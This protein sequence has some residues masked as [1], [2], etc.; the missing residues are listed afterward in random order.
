MVYLIKW[1]IS[2]ITPSSRKEGYSKD[3]DW[4]A[5][6]SSR[7]SRAASSNSG[8]SLLLVVMTMSVIIVISSSFMLLSFNTGLSS[9]F[10]SAQHKAQLSC[11]SVAEG[12]KDGNTFGSIVNQ[13][14][15][16]LSG[17]QTVVFDVNDSTLDGKT[18]VKLEPTTSGGSVKSVKVTVTT[19]VG[20]SKYE[21][22]FTH[23]MKTDSVRDVINQVTN[24]MS[25]S[26]GGSFSMQTGKVEG[27]LSLDGDYLLALN[28]WKEINDKTDG[29]TGW[30]IY[31]GT[32]DGNVYVNGSLVLGYKGAS[33]QIWKEECIGTSATRHTT[34]IP[35]II[36]ENLYVNGDLIINACEIEG[37]VYVSGNVLVNG[38]TDTM[39]GTETDQGSG[40]YYKDANNAVIKGNL[41]VGGSLYVTTGSFSRYFPDKEQVVGD[42]GST[43][44]T[45]GYRFNGGFP[46]FPSAAQIYGNQ[47][48]SDYSNTLLSLYNRTISS[49]S[50]NSNGEYVFTL[51]NGSKE[52][53]SKNFV[54]YCKNTIGWG[55]IMEDVLGAGDVKVSLEYH[56]N[57]GK[58]VILVEGKNCFRYIQG[59]VWF[60]YE[61]NSDGNEEKRASNVLFQILTGNHYTNKGES[62]YSQDGNNT[63][64]ATIVKDY[65]ARKLSASYKNLNNGSANI[66]EQTFTVSKNVYV[67]NDAFVQSS[68][69]KIGKETYILGKLTS[70]SVGSICNSDGGIVY[71]TNTAFNKLYVGGGVENY[72][73]YAQQIIGSYQNYYEAYMSIKGSGSGVSDGHSSSTKGEESPPYIYYKGRW[74]MFY[75]NGSNT[76][77]YLTGNENSYKSSSL[78]KSE[79]LGKGIA[80]DHSATLVHGIMS[81]GSYATWGKIENN[82]TG[83]TGNTARATFDALKVNEDEMYSEEFLK[84][85]NSSA[86]LRTEQK[87][88]EKVETVADVFKEM[89]V[90]GYSAGEVSTKS[91]QN[92]YKGGSDGDPQKYFYNNL[93]KTGS[94]KEYKAG[95]NKLND[96]GGVNFTGV[97]SATQ[98]KFGYTLQRAIN[99][100][101][102]GVI[103]VTSKGSISH[104][105]S[106]SGD[107]FGNS[108]ARDWRVLYKN[109]YKYKNSPVGV[110]NIENLTNYF[111]KGDGNLG[112]T[113]YGRLIFL[114]A[115]DH[116]VFRSNNYSSCSRSDGESTRQANFIRDVKEVMSY[117]YNPSLAGSNAAMWEKY[118]KEYAGV[119]GYDAAGNLCIYLMRDIYL[120]GDSYYG[121]GKDTSS[122]DCDGAGFKMY[123][124]T[125]YHSI[126]VYWGSDFNGML[127]FD[128][129]SYIEISLLFPQTGSFNVAYMYLLPNIAWSNNQS[130]GYSIMSY[131]DLR[132]H[133]PD[134]TSAEAVTDVSGKTI[135]DSDGQ[136]IFKSKKT[137]KYYKY[138]VK[139]YAEANT[140][141][142][143]KPLS[144]SDPSLNMRFT[145]IVR[146]W[147]DC[148]IK[149]TAVRNSDK[150][151]KAA[152]IPFI[153]CE[154]PMLFM[155]GQNGEMSGIIY[156][157][158]PDSVFYCASDTAY[159]TAASD[160]NTTFSGGAIVTGRVIGTR[161]NNGTWQFFED[162]DK[163]DIGDLLTKALIEDPNGISDIDTSGGTNTSGNWSAGGY[164]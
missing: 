53:L 63:L 85:H 154:G 4:R 150:S 100:S 46:S 155:M 157:P 153:M 16:D 52:T 1:L 139:S 83:Q 115:Y 136:T 39:R 151:L 30:V 164:E 3:R 93:S 35:T 145:F 69:K 8:S 11:L 101:K 104:P 80:Q 131:N 65:E 22:K 24:S 36:K 98:I 15:A 103:T 99:A 102:N 2:L 105:S 26:G 127:N 27:D 10:A 82:V 94:D 144:S 146:M 160:P 13:Y 91:F 64:R 84:N 129:K 31:P 67:Q 128:S 78:F 147:N 108:D 162:S 5:L 141:S 75:Q 42:S 118:G 48:A 112:D 132:N 18:S 86:A 92:A 142:S 33:T 77:F 57:A 156:S 20:S 89:G 28:S 32:V 90:W 123:L 38:L 126:N 122:D 71:G 138:S 61:Y 74:F 88:A 158:N 96:R 23:T 14:S 62:S 133:I 68:N 12:L 161:H 55:K 152:G 149:N 81:Y 56:S 49:K 87:R 130:S 40:R 19:N 25:V 50:T 79:N 114:G 6:A 109:D 59:L 72:T 60:H 43:I 41:Y 21:V 45:E 44:N 135:T 58:N 47:S 111:V 17:G 73:V 113:F 29:Q 125:S 51:N 137:G 106:T 110:Q 107:F 95:D 163:Y 140:G 124:D 76:D 143:D 70:Y 120:G 119:F 97:T 117:L 9:I 66:S 159:G 121:F 148:R 116:N 34:A 7:L 37:D 54:D 134:I